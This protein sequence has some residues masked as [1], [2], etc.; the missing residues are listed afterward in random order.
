MRAMISDCNSFVLY[1]FLFEDQR[2]PMIYGSLSS[3][4]S[5]LFFLISHCFIQVFVDLLN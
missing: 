3:K 5:V 1:I 2:L 4:G